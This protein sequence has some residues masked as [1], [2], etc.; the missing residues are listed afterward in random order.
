[1]TLRLPPAL[2]RALLRAAAR[3]G[4]S[5]NHYLRLCVE[6]HLKDHHTNG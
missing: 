2:K 5:L 3:E 6:A 1:M 4:L